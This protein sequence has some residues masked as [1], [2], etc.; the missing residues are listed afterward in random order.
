MDE[1]VCPVQV[2]V[3]ARPL[4]VKW[5]LLVCQLI[6]GLILVSQGVVYVHNMCE[7]FSSY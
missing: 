1:G 2:Q 6:D 7:M 5:R 3:L 4:K